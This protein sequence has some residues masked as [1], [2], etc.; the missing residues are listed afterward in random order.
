MKKLRR[1][2]I[3]MGEWQGRMGGG[4]RLIYLVGK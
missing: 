1:G 4:G 3:E 2:G